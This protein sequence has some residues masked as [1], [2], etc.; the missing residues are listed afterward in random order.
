MKK[1]LKNRILHLKNRNKKK[2]EPAG[3]SEIGEDKVIS[4]FLIWKSGYYNYIPIINI[5]YI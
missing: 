4:D 3:G 2:T 1:L 5:L